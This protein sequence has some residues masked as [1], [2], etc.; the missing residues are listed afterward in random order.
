[1][2]QRAFFL[3][4][5]T[6]SSRACDWLVTV[7]PR[8]RSGPL[9]QP[10]PP[11]GEGRV[12]GV[13][14]DPAS[15][16]AHKA[17]FEALFA[18]GRVL[19]AVGNEWLGALPRRFCGL[20]VGENPRGFKALPRARA[21]HAL[22]LLE[23]LPGGVGEAVSLRRL[24]VAEKLILCEPWDVLS[25]WL[26][27]LEPDSPQAGKKLSE[28]LAWLTP[29][30][31]VCG[32]LLGGAQ[33]CRWFWRLQ[34]GSGGALPPRP[35]ADVLPTLLSVLGISTPPA[36]QGTPVDLGK[37]GASSGYTPEDERAIQKRLEDLGYL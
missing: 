20:A 15:D 11:W 30:I 6:E 2:S 21:A 16:L 35:V 27:L 4:M 29:D 28:I 26:P 1:M 24:N 10:S 7:L 22:S 25:L 34:G 23:G 31:A 33:N 32:V 14:A 8:A 36:L 9:T 5:V 12:R 19:C 18:S 3:V 37:A 13:P 17:F